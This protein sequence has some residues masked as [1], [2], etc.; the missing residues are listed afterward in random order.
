[1][2]LD[3]PA[4]TDVGRERSLSLI[5]LRCDRGVITQVG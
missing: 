1:M 5:E 3:M 4:A 2:V